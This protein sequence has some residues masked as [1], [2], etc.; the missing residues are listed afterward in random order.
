MPGANC[1]DSNFDNVSLNVTHN[2]DNNNQNE[3]D[4]TTGTSTT[5][6]GSAWHSDFALLQRECHWMFNMFFVGILAYCLLLY[7][8]VCTRDLVRRFAGNRCRDNDDDDDVDG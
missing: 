4:N 7:F 2:N 1:I 8:T 5:G 6:G 3:V